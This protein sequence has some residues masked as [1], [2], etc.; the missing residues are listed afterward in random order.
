MSMRRAWMSAHGV[1]EQI[2]G[3]RRYIGLNREYVGLNRGSADEVRDSV[4]VIPTQM[5]GVLEWKIGP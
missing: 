5:K 2:H 1:R 3:I 4:N